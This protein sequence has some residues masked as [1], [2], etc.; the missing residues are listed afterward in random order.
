MYSFRNTK[1][2]LN[3]VSI[4]VDPVQQLQGGVKHNAL[5]LSTLN[6]HFDLTI[7]CKRFARI[8]F[9]NT[10]QSPAFV[11]PEN[12]L[13]SNMLLAKVTRTSSDRLITIVYNTLIL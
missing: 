2:Q 8:A 12:N 6:T 10:E 1:K 5:F 13:R 11:S 9:P 7:S 3:K 4:A